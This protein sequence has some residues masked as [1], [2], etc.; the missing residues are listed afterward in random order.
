MMKPTTT[1]LLGL[2]L[3]AALPGC[4][5]KSS[6]A[7]PNDSKSADAKA[8]DAKPGDTKAADAKAAGPDYAK[9]DG[10]VASAKTTEDFDKILEGC[11]GLGIDLAMSKKIEDVETDPDYWTHCKVGPARVRAQIVIK[12]STPEKMH[13]MCI[14]AAM[15][16]EEIRDAN[17]PESAEFKTLAEN[18]NKACGM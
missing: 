2:L 11:M 13:T 6:D 9:I 12:E 14:T 10:L 4:D 3:T 1:A 15:I 18:V 5:T 16:A 8:G 7:K 17:K